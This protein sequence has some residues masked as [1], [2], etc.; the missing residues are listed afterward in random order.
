MEDQER[1]VSPPQEPLPPAKI[2]FRTLVLSDLH[3]GTKDA[4]ARELLDVLRG[5][6]CDKLILNGDIVDLWSLRRKNYWTP[7]HTAVLR[8]I[9]KM[10]EKD[11]TKVVY[12]R[13]NHDDFIRHL[14]PIALDRIELAE[15]THPRRPAGSAVPLH[16]RRRL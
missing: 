11:G 3:L 10:A 8:R 6:R 4:Q 12:L 7:A 15:R 13:G 14:L 1:F 5:I 16:P 2:H 9:M